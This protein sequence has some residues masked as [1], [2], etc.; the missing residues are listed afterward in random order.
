MWNP[1]GELRRTLARLKT[2]GHAARYALATETDLSDAQCDEFR[3]Q[4]AEADRLLV[5]GAS[6]RGASSQI[7]DAVAL[8]ERCDPLGN[9]KAIKIEYIGHLAATC[10]SLMTAGEMP[11][12][13]YLR[14]L[15]SAVCDF[16]AH[17]FACTADETAFAWDILA[18]A[19][20]G[21][22]EAT[23][24]T[25]YSRAQQRYR[26]RMPGEAPALALVAG[27]AV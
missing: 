23:D 7:A 19:E 11:D 6:A 18:Q 14:A 10:D 20:A 22:G 27:T 3:A 2:L 4:I 16:E 21:L 25:H 9:L 8:L 17:H 26:R 12:A 13:S 24:E 15:A 1:N 5:Q